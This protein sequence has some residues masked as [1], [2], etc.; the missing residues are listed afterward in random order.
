M[1]Q[2]TLSGFSSSGS[3]VS[4]SMFGANAVFSRTDDGA[5]S[6]AYTS[7]ASNLGVTSVRFGGGQSD[8]APQKVYGPG[9]VPVDGEDWINI[10]A[11]PDGNLRPELVNFFE[12]CSN[13]GGGGPEAD[14]VCAVLVI[15]TKHLNTED[16]VGF[17]DDISAFVT[18]V[19]AQ[20]GHLIEAFQIGN[21]HWD[22]GETAYG[23]RASIAA[24]A[25]E[26]GMIEAGID[27]ADQPSIIVQMATAGNTG[28]EFQATPGVH[29]FRQRNDD[30]N[31]QIIDQLSDTARNAIDGVTEHYY[32]NKS[33]YEFGTHSNEVN[34]IDR[35]FDV[36]TEAFAKD[37]DLHITEWN[38]RTTTVAQHG[39]VAG[40]TLIRQFENM[41]DLG[42]DAANIWAL[43]YHSRTAL[44]LETDDGARVDGQGRMMNSSQAAAFDLMA[45]SI[46]GKE[47]ISASFLETFPELAV[48]AYADQDT[49]VLYVS[50]RTLDVMDV[51]LDLSAMFQNYGAITGVKVSLDTN[52][53]NGLQWDNGIAA[54][55]VTIDG[56]PY[57]YNEHDVDVL[58][59]D[60]TFSDVSNISFDLKP[61]E[62][63]ELTIETPPAPVQLSAFIGTD[64]DDLIVYDALLGEADGGGGLDHL[65][66]EGQRHE[67]EINQ[68]ADGHIAFSHS[69]TPHDLK[70]EGVE[71]IWFE[72]GAIAFDVEGN[73]GQAYRLYQ[74]SFDRT[75]DEAGLGFWIGQLDDGALSLAE[76]A[77]HFIESVEFSQTHGDNATL[78]EAEYLDL[79]Y[80]NVLDRMPD[81]AG[82][83]FW[84]MQQDNGLSRAEMLTFFSESDEVKTNVSAAVED[85][86]WFV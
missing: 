57:F 45:G 55:A 28:S 6:E 20:Y 59:S 27:T 64:A 69:E 42:V 39:F 81:Q 33:H 30:A 17:A 31:Q 83:D 53:A 29:D 43:D 49:T 3:F 36:W 47:L 44:T 72:D 18:T 82:Y 34:F 86:I 37:L 48:A 9:E 58:F 7:A 2:L 85:G 77:Q 46:A 11:M 68:H 76:I 40:S 60:L 56:D 5:P 26:T 19:M 8:L 61:F 13:G 1:P 73:G 41:I 15:P 22:I 63:V 32:Y 4:K 66:V 78:S 21:E 50:S 10:V 75:P 52:S 65:L 38:I 80:H 12:W 74:A 67:V 35:D 24:E 16:Y 54:D 70:L 14:P 62:F 71:R 84:S 51:T 25:I 23:Q 79:L